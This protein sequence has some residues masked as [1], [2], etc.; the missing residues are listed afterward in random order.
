MEHPVTDVT[1]TMLTPFVISTLRQADHLANQ[2][3]NN[4]KFVKLHT[5]LEKKPKFN[6]FNLQVLNA[7]QEAKSKLSQMPLVLIPIHFDRSPIEKVTSFQRSVV[8][9]TFITQDFMT[10]VPAVPG[11]TLSMDVLTKMV[12]E[13]KSVPGI[14]RVLYDLTPKPPGTTEWE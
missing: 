8:I 3:N 4:K 14:S 13:I 6:V 9:R 5:I 1:P 2:V 7:N 11:E 10:G 12:S